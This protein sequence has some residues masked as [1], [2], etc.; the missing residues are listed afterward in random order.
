MRLKGERLGDLREDFLP[1]PAVAE[2]LFRAVLQ[3]I[4][5]ALGQYASGIDA[6]DA[7]AMVDVSPPSARV[8]AI[9]EAFPVVPAM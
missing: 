9:S 7:H 6:H 4:D 3:V 8:N 5:L 2:L 1:A